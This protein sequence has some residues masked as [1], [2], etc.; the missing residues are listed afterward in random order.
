MLSSNLHVS[1][2]GILQLIMPV[3]KLVRLT[4][5]RLYIIGQVSMHRFFGRWSFFIISL[6]WL[7]ITKQHLIRF[8]LHQLI[9]RSIIVVFSLKSF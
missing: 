7:V 2:G 8:G 9:L 6:L 5:E 3:L 1:F 4:R